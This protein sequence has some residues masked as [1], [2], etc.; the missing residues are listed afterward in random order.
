M[1]STAPVPQKSV[2]DEWV[3]ASWDEFLAVANSPSLEACRFYY[4]NHSMRIEMVPLGSSHSQDDPVVSRVIS[5]FATVKN[6]RI[7]E[8]GNGSFRKTGEQG[9][10]PDIAFY[11]G[12]T[13]PFPPRGSAPINLDEINPPALVVEIASTT[14]T[15][16]LGHKRLLY[17]RLGVQEYWVVDVAGGQVIAFA[18]ADGGSR[19]IRESK[20]L[21]GLLMDVVE[22]ALRRSQVEDDGTVNRWLLQT[23]T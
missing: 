6:L 13:V 20:V 22:E 16:D 18:V 3:Q 12:A 11:I 10:Q 23:L 1:V 15:D 2:T 17:E 5:L 21:P 4:D 9:C 14:L 8:I 19:Q 7:K